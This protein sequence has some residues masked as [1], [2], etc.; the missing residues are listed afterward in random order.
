[1]AQSLQLRRWSAV[2]LVVMACSVV[3]GCTVAKISGRG[4]VPLMLN[5]PTSRVTVVGRL[6]ES[7]LKVFDYTGAFDVSEVIADALS[8]TQATGVTNLVV[9]IKTTIPSYLVNVVTLGFANARVF[10]VEGDLVNLGADVPE[11]DE[12]ARSKSLEDVL[13]AAAQA[14]GPGLMLSK[15][16][17]EWVLTRLQD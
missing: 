15:A 13:E 2:A 1:M 8:R 9:T 5:N 16:G 10:Q 14:G 12:L 11:A 6:K 7:K 17:S 3:Q 4:S